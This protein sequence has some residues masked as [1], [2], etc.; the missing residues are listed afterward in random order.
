MCYKRICNNCKREIPKD[1]IAYGVSINP[2]HPLIECK[3]CY[4]KHKRIRMPKK[5]VNSKNM[6]NTP[7]SHVLIIKRNL[8]NSK[9]LHTQTIFYHKPKNAIM[10]AETILRIDDSLQTIDLCRIEKTWIGKTIVSYP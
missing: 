1:E 7:F 3:E 6:I 5:S 10:F 4:L 2:D 9:P 8:D